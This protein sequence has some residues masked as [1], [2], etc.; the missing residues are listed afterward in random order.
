MAMTDLHW[1][2]VDQVATVWAD[3]PGPLRAGLLFRTGRADETL[4]TAGLTHLVEHLAFSAVNDP[5][6]HNGIVGGLW[7][8]F[9]TMGQPEAVSD[10]LAKICAGLNSLPGDRLESEKQVLEAENASRS[11]NFCNNLLMW[12]YG[13]N[14]YGLLGMPEL[15]LRKL[16][17][18]Q[19]QNHVA[20]RFTRQNAILWLS[21]SVPDDLR[22]TLPDGIKHP[23]PPLTPIQETF[24]CWF[25]DDRCGGVA[26]G[27]IVPR[28]YAATIFC[29][30]ASR[31]LYNRL[32]TDQAVS[33]APTV[34]Y[35]PLNADIA[36]LVL[37]A[38]SDQN[39]RAELANVFDE[40]FQ[41]LNI[42]EHEEMASARNRIL[43]RWIGSL[44]PPPADLYVM[45]LQRSA[46]DWILGN[47]YESLETQA[48]QLNLVTVEEVASFARGVQANAMFALP[49]GAKLLPG[50]GTMVPGSMAPVV[51]GH[52]AKNM[53]SPIRREELVYGPDGVSVV[54]PNGSH[55]TI[56]F[57][58]LAAALSYE[59]GCVQLI[60]Y[61]AT[62][63]AVEPSLWRDGPGIC[64][65][66]RAHIP[67]HLL[68][69]QGTRAADVIPKPTTTAWQRFRARLLSFETSENDPGLKI[70]V[71]VLLFIGILFFIVFLRWVLD[72]LIR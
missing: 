28:V 12:R 15:G 29:E 13:A 30:I 35:E 4:A 38:D 43:D 63:V 61:D 45:E 64:R 50:F 31:R 54:W 41:Q 2:E 57:S 47:E 37:Y 19:L 6:Q 1:T 48:S 16:T 3:T 51:Q 49:G 62:W 36:H 65:Q 26:A 46:M 42:L 44:I 27:I 10:F 7:T 22:L 71:Y 67:E 53:D 23:I 18:E 68:I 52:R 24:P 60:G 9:F 69:D 25:V 39:R 66:I 70:F 56:R 5:Q 58:E 33:Y 72:N 17:L 59:D 14:G 32:R 34:Y 55:G 8:G 11:Y 40:V 21:G 20:Q